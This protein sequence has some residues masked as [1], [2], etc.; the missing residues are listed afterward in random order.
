MLWEREPLSFFREE[1]WRLPMVFLVITDQ[2]DVLVGALSQA[3]VVAEHRPTVVVIEVGAG[4]SP[5]AILAVKGVRAVVSGGGEQGTTV[6]GDVTAIDGLSGGEKIFV[7][8]W[9]AAQSSG[10]KVRIGDGLSWD[11]PGFQPP[12]PKKKPG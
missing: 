4:V 10:A 3:R 9:A 7:R 2:P 1:L 6:A 11:A 5:T 8:G 12:D